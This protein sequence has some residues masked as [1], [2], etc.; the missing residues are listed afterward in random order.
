MDETGPIEPRPEPAPPD[1][2]SSVP[3]GPLSEP[4]LVDVPPP[5]PPLDWS[6]GSSPDAP[7]TGTAVD[8]PVRWDAPPEGGGV[9]VPGAPD[10]VYAGTVARVVAFILD[11]L[12]LVVLSVVLAVALIGVLGRDGYAGVVATTAFLVLDLVYFVVL[13]TGRRRATFG[14]RLLKLQIGNA[15]DGRSITREQAVIRWLAYGQWLYLLTIAPALANLGNLLAFVWSVVLV[16]SIAMN[17]IHQG[18]HDRFA[19]TAIVQ[20]RGSS[21]GLLVGCVVIVAVFGLITFVGIVA[22]IFLGGQVSGLQTTP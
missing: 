22:L 8:P 14:M 17:A 19:E 5:A 16:V 13:W 6:A 2:A 18:L 10:L 4:P 9:A 7:P 20:A 15:M 1:A 11:S 21:N 12:I 3:G